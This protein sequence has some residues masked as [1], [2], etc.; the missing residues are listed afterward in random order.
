M[1]DIELVSPLRAADG[2]QER[3]ARELA[4]D[5]QGGRLDVAWLLREGEVFLVRRPED[6]D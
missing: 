6:A 3:F 4:S 1:T 5:L 2:D